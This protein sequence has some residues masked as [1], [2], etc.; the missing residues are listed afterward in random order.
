MKNLREKNEKLICDIVNYLKENKSVVLIFLIIFIMLLFQNLS[1]SMYYDDFGNAS[2]SYGYVTPNV[3][4][5]DYNFSQ[6]M[7]WSSQIYNTWGGR[8]LYA[9]FII[10]LLKFG[11]TRY[12][13]VQTFVMAALFFVM[14]KI[15]NKITNSKNN[16]FV[17]IVMF[18]LYMGID[19]TFLKHGV[20]WA[21]ASILYVWPMLPLFTLIYAYISVID[22]IKEKKK[23][24]ICIYLPIMIILSFLT[25][26][27]QEQIGIAMI[28]FF[29]MYILIDHIKE[30][31][32]Y[33]VVDGILLLSSIASYLA[34]FLAPGNW[35]RMNTNDEFNNFSLFE[36]ISNNFTPIIRSIFSVNMINILIIISICMLILIFKIVK[37]NS[38][39]N[40]KYML[41][42]TIPII[43]IVLAIIFVF[44]DNGYIYVTA[45]IVW[46]LSF[47]VISLLYVKNTKSV[48]IVIALEFAAAASVFCLLISPN[49]PN[50]VLL[51]LIFILILIIS[52]TFKNLFDKG[53]RT[54][55]LVMIIWIGILLVYGTKL[56]LKTY[57][58]YNENYTINELN[59]RILSSYNGED[60]TIVLY[61]L[62]DSW[63]A[64]TMP[65]DEESIYYWM[66]EYFD[67][68]MDVNFV[69]IDLY[70][71]VKEI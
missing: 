13:V 36:K 22:K 43:L 25:C 39:K 16:I 11:I 6:I 29:I 21:S 33:I 28:V 52:A 64:S 55:K 23:I 44:T 3:A 30:I 41:L 66:W 71:G 18:A 47:L 46:L 20:Y 15:S 69:W 57:R 65:Y 53:N 8:I 61:K 7:E 2:L 42:Y 5:S 40:K 27:S 1:V 67:I 59:F 31:K 63:Y 56:Y 34:L 32:K 4:G 24:N 26:F 51:P 68:P 50:R 14:Y 62:K 19:M 37:D 12:M 60:K 58:G 35:V 54:L 70:E 9:N 45:C 17:P 10:P 38:K 48:G 49:M